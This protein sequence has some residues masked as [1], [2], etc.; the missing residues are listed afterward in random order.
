MSEKTFAL[1][2]NPVLYLPK[3]LLALSFFL[4]Y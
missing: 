3:A 4:V 1:L 2:F